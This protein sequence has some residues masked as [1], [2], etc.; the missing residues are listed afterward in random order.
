M[1]TLGR[2]TH[3]GEEVK[4]KKGST[5]YNK[6]YEYLGFVPIFIN[7]GLYN[8]S[9][10][11]EKDIQNSNN[12]KYVFEY[13]NRF[14][15]IH[16][17]INTKEVSWV[18]KKSTE[19]LELP[20][21]I[22]F[23]INS[24]YE[25]PNY[26][27]IA[28]KCSEISFNEKWSDIKRI[29]KEKTVED[30]IRTS[31]NN[32]KSFKESFK[33]MFEELGDYKIIYN[34]VK[35]IKDKDNK[36]TKSSTADLYLYSG[37]SMDVLLNELDGEYKINNG[38]VCLKSCKFIQISL[39]KNSDAIVGAMVGKMEELSKFNRKYY[40]ESILK[41]CKDI[42]KEFNN[43]FEIAKDKFECVGVKDKLDFSEGFL[44]ER[45][46]TSNC[47]TLAMLNNF[48]KNKLIDFCGNYNF[49]K[50][51]ESL[52]EIWAYTVF[53]STKFPLY[54]LFGDINYTYCGTF[55]EYKNNLKNYFKDSTEPLFVLSSKKSQ[56]GYYIIELYIT[57][58]IINGKNYYIRTRT[59]PKNSDSYVSSFVM[60]GDKL[61]NT[62]TLEELRRI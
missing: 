59:C 30:Y 53:G 4:I 17:G 23:L 34:N 26:I 38:V 44:F 56:N 58:Y 61:T 5:L 51:L 43:N 27:E 33:K 24:E 18:N 20:L 37:E 36:G 2:E 55:E 9:Y 49:E 12:S 29:W 13:D 14:F 48:Y 3:I 54:K 8:K 19:E 39:K 15:I 46:T 16:S 50:C 6:I 22:S 57:R 42:V 40:F 11:I 25:I 7:R 1:A 60:N 47:M 62:K 52:T 10:T 35:R 32:V 31:F 28:D 21:V 41:D 45:M